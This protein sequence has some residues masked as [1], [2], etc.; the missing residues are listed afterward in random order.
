[1]SFQMCRLMVLPMISQA[2]MSL[3]CAIIYI[4]LRLRYKVLYWPSTVLN[5]INLVMQLYLEELVHVGPNNKPF[6]SVPGNEPNS[7]D[8]RTTVLKSPCHI[9]W[10]G[11]HSQ[12][13]CLGGPQAMV[14]TLVA[15]PSMQANCQQEALR[16]AM[17]HI[18]KMI[19]C[20][21]NLFHKSL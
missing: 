10:A 5:V 21:C 7:R 16:G 4:L 17:G 19:C 6:E 12:R 11:E 20:G 13:Q 2:L 8:A 9:S 15:L 18:K 1:M 14:L 3:M